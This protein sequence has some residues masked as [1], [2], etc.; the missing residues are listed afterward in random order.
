M[1]GGRHHRRG[2]HLAAGSVRGTRRRMQT[3]SIRQGR[4]A[5]EDLKTLAGDHGRKD[6]ADALP[7][8]VVQQAIDDRVDAAV[9]VRDQ[10]ETGH[11]DAEPEALMCLPVEQHIHLPGVERKPA[12]REQ[13]D[14]ED[15][16]PDH[17]LLLPQTLPLR[18][19]LDRRGA[20]ESHRGRQRHRTPQRA[21]DPTVREEHQKYRK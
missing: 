3:E 20:V 19:D 5:P 17:S 2:A 8:A 10:L 14:D 13:D 21:Y 16:H 4:L 7:E 9:A 6:L 12:D 11:P 15:Q 18:H 1:I